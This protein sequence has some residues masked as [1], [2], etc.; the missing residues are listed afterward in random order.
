MITIAH[1]KEKDNKKILAANNAVGQQKE[2]MP[3]I[4]HTK[5]IDNKK[6]LAA[7][8][9]VGQQKEAMPIIAHKKKKKDN[10]K[11]LAAKNAVGQQKETRTLKVHKKEKDKK[12][13]GKKNKKNTAACAAI[14]NKQT[15]VC[16]PPFLR[17]P[18][19][20][21]WRRGVESQV[22]AE[23]D[24][25]KAGRLLRDL[26]PWQEAHT[27]AVGHHA[28]KERDRLLARFEEF[29][30]TMPGTT[31]VEDLVIQWA[32]RALKTASPGVV[33]NYM[34][35]L[36]RA[37]ADD[38]G[39]VISRKVIR[40][41]KALSRMGV[42]IRPKQATPLHTSEVMAALK[43]LRQS[44]HN[45]AAAMVAICWM[46][47]ARI[48][49]IRYVVKADWREVDGQG[50]AAHLVD[51]EVHAKEKA[52]LQWQPAI[53]LPRGQITAVAVEFWRQATEGGLVFGGD[54]PRYA[55][56]KRQILRVM[57]KLDGQ[58]WT[59]SLRRG[60]AQQMDLAGTSRLHI[61]ESLRHQDERQ[62][63][64]YLDSTNATRRGKERSWM[65]RLQ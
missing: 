64:R 63:L 13:K 60:A 25:K 28:A 29:R 35:R 53:F 4:A 36:C 27:F 1:K 38:E 3:I 15:G 55:V 51:A 48:S 57:P 46:T 2:A 23:R 19:T 12:K 31:T 58:W 24:G 52:R 49:D 7:N 47:R 33:R 34:D 20:A 61:K 62:T 54:T 65:R 41:K 14:V 42:M 40:V 50:G 9:A 26:V 37:I 59:H 39:W 30:S 17:P 43:L 45:T 44:G 18:S 11:I 6:I 5:K 10:K 21:V 8:V 32:W 16:P 22:F 56:L